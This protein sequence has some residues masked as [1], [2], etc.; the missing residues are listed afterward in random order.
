MNKKSDLA[1]TNVSQDA[2][3]TPGS[4]DLGVL[5][6]PDVTPEQ[7][8]ALGVLE[9][10]YT[11]GNPVTD[12][13]FKIDASM[14]EW[15]DKWHNPQ[16]PLGWFQWWEGYAS[17]KR[18]DDDD[19]QI[20]RWISF[21]A[22]H[23]AQLRKADP[24]LE[25][26]S[27]QP[28]RRQALLNWGVAPGIKM[29]KTENKFL[30]KIAS[31]LAQDE[32][33][34]KP[35]GN[36]GRE[37]GLTAAGGALGAGIGRAVAHATG[38]GLADKTR[39]TGIGGIAGLAAGQIANLAMGVH[40]AHNNRRILKEKGVAASRSFPVMSALGTYGV[41]GHH[42]KKEAAEIQ[43]D[44]GGYAVPT[45][46]GAAAGVGAGAGASVLTGRDFG[47]R[48]ARH[49]AFKSHLAETRSNNFR[50]MGNRS[51]GPINHQFQQYFR[52]AARTVEGH[53]PSRDAQVRHGFERFQEA[54][55]DAKFLSKGSKESIKR[56][57]DHTL[58]VAKNLPQNTARR[59]A[60]FGAVGAGIGALAGAAHH[61]DN[62]NQKALNNYL[63]RQG[64]VGQD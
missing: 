8:K 61:M 2:P 33:G 32:L 42:L 13:F 44:H 36:F 1:K 34:L 23:L 46:V 10:K 54:K 21:K 17:G 52:D 20:K 48:W 60:Q 24:S 49:S 3:R 14:S 7:A 12:N 45:A 15:P 4:K 55:E 30:E 31:R 64:A 41:H 27:I 6:R 29:D 39:S 25:D 58:R 5:F 35:V 56:L 47:E 43:K 50:M 40:N 16:H 63:I 22:R 9:G 26:L 19:R 37:L 18:T 28:R 38:K 62:N 53:S 11:H 51:A 57:R 59:V